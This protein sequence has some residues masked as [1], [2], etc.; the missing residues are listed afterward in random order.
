[1]VAVPTAPVTIQVRPEDAETALGILAEHFEMDPESEDAQEALESKDEA[2]T[3]DGRGE[4][5]A[6]EFAAEQGLM[7]EP[8]CEKEYVDCV[9]VLT[10]CNDEEVMVVQSV[11]GAAGIPC[12]A[13]G[14]LIQD[15]IGWRLGAGYSLLLGPVEIQVR[16]EDAETARRVLAERSAEKPEADAE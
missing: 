16:A 8:E 14:E 5:T 7:D 4:V 3:A 1:M 13:K 12:Y 2:A 10:A 9:T 6:D 15:L 11:L